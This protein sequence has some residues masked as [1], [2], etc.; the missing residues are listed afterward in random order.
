VL[1]SKETHTFESRLPA[2]AIDALVPAKLTT[3]TFGVG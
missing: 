3:A 1:S 2:P